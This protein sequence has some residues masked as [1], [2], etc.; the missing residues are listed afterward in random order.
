MRIIGLINPMK[1]AI[2]MALL[3]YPFASVTLGATHNKGN[4][5]PDEVMLMNSNQV[6]VTESIVEVHGQ[7][8]HLVEYQNEVFYFPLL[9]SEKATH[10]IAQ[11]CRESSAQKYST[12]TH[13]TLETRFT[14]VPES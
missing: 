4:L 7:R 13:E 6:P 1:R 3:I 14:V 5:V 11:F 9:Q 2:I 12:V 10:E 8:Y